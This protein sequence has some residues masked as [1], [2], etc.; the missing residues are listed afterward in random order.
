MNSVLIL[1]IEDVC[2]FID[3]IGVKGTSSFELPLEQGMRPEMKD[4]IDLMVN[5]LTLL[6]NKG[7][8]INPVQSCIAVAELDYL[9]FTISKKGRLPREEKMKAIKSF[10]VPKTV[11]QAELFLGM[12]NFYLKFIIGFAEAASPIYTLIAEG[13]KAKSKKLNWNDKAEKGFQLLKESL[14]KPPVLRERMLYSGQ[15]LIEFSLF[16]LRVVHYM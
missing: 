6:N 15:G 5:I 1:V 8:K 10:P 2:V 12:V 16:N 13:R 9:G 4:H 3:D 14:T 7:L 11:K